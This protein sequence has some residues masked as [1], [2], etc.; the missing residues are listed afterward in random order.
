MGEPG[1]LPSMGS[2][3][4]GHDWSDLAAAAAAAIQ[5]YKSWPHL[6]LTISNN[7]CVTVGTQRESTKRLKCVPDRDYN[8]WKWPEMKMRKAYAYLNLWKNSSHFHKLFPLSGTFLHLVSCSSH[9][10]CISS[11]KII[12]FKQTSLAYL[13]PQHFSRIINC[14]HTPTALFL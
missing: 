11:L 2:H 13:L 1:G 4:V 14:S 8:T 10:F 3:R 5:S 7:L 6:Y 9:L 12:F